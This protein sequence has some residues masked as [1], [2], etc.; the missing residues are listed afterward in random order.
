[1]LGAVVA[2]LTLMLA[3]PLWAS[4][5]QPTKTPLNI[6]ATYV[7]QTLCGF[8]ITV[9]ASLHGFEIHFYDQ[10]GNETGSQVH[11]TEQD[12]FSANGNSLASLLYTTNIKLVRDANGDLVSAEASGVIAVV[13][14]PNGETFFSAGRVD[15]LSQVGD[16]VYQVDSGTVRNHDAFCAA[17]AA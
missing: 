3:A 7:T 8:P 15:Y 1:M 9:H 2:P 5:V 11:V 12:V 17:L 14:L 10:S 6:D 13:P 4:A 16:F